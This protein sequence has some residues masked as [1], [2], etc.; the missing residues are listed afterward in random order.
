MQENIHT[1]QIQKKK[2]ITMTG[3]LLRVADVSRKANLRK[4]LITD[5]NSENFKNVKGR[6][7]GPEPKLEKAQPQAH[8]H[9]WFEV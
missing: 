5:S 6:R 1:G 7:T 8:H 2:T 4:Q 3:Q 9:E